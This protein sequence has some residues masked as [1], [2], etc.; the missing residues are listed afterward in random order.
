MTELYVGNSQITCQH[1]AKDIYNLCDMILKPREITKADTTGWEGETTG[2]TILNKIYS[3]D[4]RK[5]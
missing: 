1:Y 5:G 3:A 2:G 4:R